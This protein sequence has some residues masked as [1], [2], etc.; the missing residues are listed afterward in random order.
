MRSDE[1]SLQ[2]REIDS[3]RTNDALA[4]LGNSSQGQYYRFTDPDT[5]LQVGARYSYLLVDVD[6]EGRRQTHGPVDIIYTPDTD[7]VPFTFEL[8]GNYPNPFNAGTTIRFTVPEKQTVAVRIYD[9]RGRLIREF[10]KFLYYPGANL[11]YWDGRDNY[12]RAV[13]SGVYIYRVS[14]RDF[15]AERKMVLLK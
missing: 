6:Y 11:V 5:A 3:Y 15:Q 1:Q 14:T 4:G 7:D 2:Y 13:A 8:K 9:L 10:P 12:G